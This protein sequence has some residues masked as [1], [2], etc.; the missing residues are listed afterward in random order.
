MANVEA[1]QIIETQLLGSLAGQ[2]TRNVLH[3]VVESVTGPAIDMAAFSAGFDARL[4]AAG[5]LYDR[6]R[7]FAPN[8]LDL[9]TRTFQQIWPTRYIKETIVSAYT[10]ANVSPAQTANVAGVVTKFGEIARRKDIGSLHV[11]APGL[12]PGATNGSFDAANQTLLNA[13]ALTIKADVLFTVT[14]TDF[15][16]APVIYHR[17]DP[18]N[19][20]PLFTAAA[21]STVRVMRRRTVGVGE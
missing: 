2:R 20:T 18:G 14:T 13:I 21:R 4:R 17:T 8:N 1:G 12:S 16:L 5:Q 11:V 10:G 9:S 6:I 7:Q 19:P 3:W 15:V